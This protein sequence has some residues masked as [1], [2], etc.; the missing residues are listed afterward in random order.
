[1]ERE[2]WIPQLPFVKELNPA[3]PL[4][5]S[6]FCTHTHTH[7]MKEKN[8][9]PPGCPRPEEDMCG[10][11]AQHSK[12]SP[13]SARSQSQSPAPVPSHVSL[14]CVGSVS[15]HH[16]GDLEVWLSRP[17]WGCLGPFSWGWGEGEESELLALGMW[18]GLSQA[19]EMLPT[20]AVADNPGPRS[21]GVGGVGKD[22]E[23][24]DKDPWVGRRLQRGQAPAAE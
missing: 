1:M 16:S 9:S 23:V 18:M 8:H 22:T 4:P 13:R 15:L 12:S 14:G 17:L 6:P 10:T 3:T 24:S 21:V 11:S 20:L 19:T 2:W 5:F 7:T